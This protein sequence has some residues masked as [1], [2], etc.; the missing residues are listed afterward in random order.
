MDNGTPDPLIRPWHGRRSPQPDGS[1]PLRVLLI[2]DDRDDFLLTQES[3]A[4]SPAGASRSNGSPTYEAGLE[5][6]CAGTHDV[7]LLDYRLGA[8]TGIEL[9]NEARGRGCSGPVILLTGQGQSSTDLDALH[10]GADDY[11][12]KGG[13]TPSLLERPCVTRSPS[14]R[15]PPNSKTRCASGPKRWRR[16][17][18]PCGNATA[19]RTSSFP[20]SATNSVTRSP[21]SSTRWKSCGSPRNNPR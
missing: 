11:L 13:L 10:A 21:R 20:R 16:P 7:Y 1:Q 2:D 3:F 14:T 19:A 9:L 12:E 17:T 15:P 8:K 5:A 6:I 4:D 18:T